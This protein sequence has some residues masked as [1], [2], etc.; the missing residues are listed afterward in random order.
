MNK[1][2]KIIIW[3]VIAVVIIVGIWYEVNKKLARNNT[4]KIG[5]VLALTGKGADLSNYIK[6]G[7]DLAVEKYG[8]NNIQLVYEDDSCDPKK[9]VSAFEKLTTVD[10]VKVIIGSFCSSATLAMAPI[11]EARKIVLITP[12]SSAEDIS[13][14]GDFIFRNHSR[15]SLEMTKFGLFMGKK[16]KNI[17]IFFDK[18]NDGTVSAAKYF[19][20]GVVE[21]GG[22]IIKSEGVSSGQSYATEI[23]KIKSDL[24][25]ASAIHIEALAQ[26]AVVMVK[27]MAEFGIKKQLSFD[28]IVASK[29]FVDPLGKLTEGIL[30]IEPK[31]DKN[32]DPDFTESYQNKYNIDPN[33][34]SAQGYDTFMI[35]A[36]IMEEKC[37]NDSVCVKNELY[38][39]KDYHG[40]GGLI[41]FDQNGDVEKEEI[42]KTVKNGQFVPYGE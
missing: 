18:T 27:K 36:K 20:D 39:I 41:S 13:Q 34:F 15:G 16:F 12:A 31:F 11:A 32:T 29:E 1:T 19:Q 26:D 25:K 28:K 40:A 42:I 7:I 9:A 37:G 14:S 33:V 10:G 2:T 38:R 30:Y 23:I 6:N 3:I 5:V 21:A 8:R 24:E 17:V 35:L 4:I 22:N